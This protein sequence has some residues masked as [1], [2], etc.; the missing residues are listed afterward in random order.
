MWVSELY[1]NLY[2]RE[3]F[4]WIKILHHE[5]HVRN[6]CKDENDVNQWMFAELEAVAVENN[7]S[8][9]LHNKHFEVYSLNLDGKWKR[10]ALRLVEQKKENENW[11]REIAET[12]DE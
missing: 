6:G 8:I 3:T 10:F 7:Y 2:L 4:N 11:N 12:G 1:G 5:K 9:R